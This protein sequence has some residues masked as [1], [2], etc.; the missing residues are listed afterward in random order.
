[1]KVI[2]LSNHLPLQ[3]VLGGGFG[4]E[5]VLQ[6]AV[7]ERRLPPVTR[8]LL[9]RRHA[10]PV[11]IREPQDAVAD[12]CGVLPSTSWRLV[13][14]C[15]EFGVG[16][17]G[18]GVDGTMGVIGASPRSW[19]RMLNESRRCN[20]TQR[21]RYDG[22][23][24]FFFHQSRVRHVIKARGEDEFGFDEAL[25]WPLRFCER[26]VLLRITCYVDQSSMGLGGLKNN[27]LLLYHHDVHSR[28]CFR[29]S[30][31]MVYYFT[32]NVVSPPAQIYV[33]KDKFESALHA[34]GEAGILLTE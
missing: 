13:E 28:F 25:G 27:A 7:T 4:E 20:I 29:H 5:T 11:R 16:L 21:Q 9:R 10:R 22:R 12:L 15:L 18:E 31:T 34:T 24:T 3:S 19:A 17:W 32:S 26:R 30:R 1:M 2:L 8:V 23:W 14:K 33:G 6:G